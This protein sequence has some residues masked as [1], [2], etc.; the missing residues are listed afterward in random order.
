MLLTRVIQQLVMVSPGAACSDFRWLCRRLFEMPQTGAGLAWSE[1]SHG[2]LQWWEPLLL[3][4]G[5]SMARHC[6]LFLLC[7]VLSGKHS[8]VTQG[9]CTLKL[10]CF[11]E[12]EYRIHDK[13]NTLSLINPWQARKA[14]VL[15][16]KC[17]V[18]L[19]RCEF[20]LLNSRQFEPVMLLLSVK[21]A[22]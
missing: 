1:G 15:K 18:W 20:I 4:D 5:G 16:G 3:G 13:G 22:D 6:T 10:Q 7:R 2:G 9:L 19:H 11:P 8:L 12:P 17:E 21:K 14:E